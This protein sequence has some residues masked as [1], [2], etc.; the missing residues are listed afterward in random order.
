M[1]DF[2]LILL[3]IV[4]MLAVPLFFYNYRR[5][6]PAQR[7]QILFAAVGAFVVAGGMLCF[8]AFR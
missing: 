3:F 2:A 5:A 4:A 1:N 7:R 8:F 6:T